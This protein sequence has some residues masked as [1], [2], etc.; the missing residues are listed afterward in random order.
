M[1]FA[2]RYLLSPPLALSHEAAFPRLV[3]QLPIRIG[4]WEVLARDWQRGK[5]EKQGTPSL[6]SLLLLCL[7]R[8][9]S[10]LHL[11]LDDSSPTA[12]AP[13]RQP[14]RPQLKQG[15]W[16]WTPGSTSPLCGRLHLLMSGIRRLPLCSVGFLTHTPNCPD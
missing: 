1:P 12:P 4:Q 5:G 13:D 8:V 3:C 16:L 2:L 11:W 9:S 6:S 10:M 14:L 15:S 7:G